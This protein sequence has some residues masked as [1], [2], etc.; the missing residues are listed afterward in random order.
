MQF[1]SCN[2][3][4]A[5]K[6]GVNCSRVSLAAGVAMDIIVHIYLNLHKGRRLL[7]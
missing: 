5:G 4:S 3:R 2:Q 1:Y 7:S 6:D